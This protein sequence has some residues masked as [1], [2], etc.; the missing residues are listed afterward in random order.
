M[1]DNYEFRGLNEFWTGKM[2]VCKAGKGGCED[3]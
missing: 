3:V 1:F 2:Q